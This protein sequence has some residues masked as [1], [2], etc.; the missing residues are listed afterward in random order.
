MS[1]RM[2]CFIFSH[3]YFNFCQNIHSSY[4]GML[5]LQ[6]R[7]PRRE[8]RDFASMPTLGSREKACILAR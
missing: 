5:L 2:I 8:K 3:I 4:R 6:R 7:Y 1:L